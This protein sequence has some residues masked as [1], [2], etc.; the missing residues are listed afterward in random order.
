[1]ADTPEKPELRKLLK[2]YRVFH[3][4]N[5]REA[6]GHEDHFQAIQ[7]LGEYDAKHYRSTVTIDEFE[8]EI[9]QLLKN[10]KGTGKKPD[11]L[12]GLR[13]TKRLERIL[14][15]AEGPTGEPIRSFIRT[16]PLTANCQPLLFPFLVLEAKSEKSDDTFSKIRLQTSFSIRALL[17][18]Q[19]DLASAVFEQQQPV[20]K[21]LVWFLSNKGEVWRLAG[22][23]VQET[24]D[25]TRPNY[26]ILDLWE[27][28]ITYEQHALRLL[29]TLD[30]IFDWA[31]DVYRKEITNCLLSL[32][33]HATA[34]LAAE[35]DVFS[36]LGNLV[37]IGQMQDFDAEPVDQ[38]PQPFDVPDLYK[39]FD[40]NTLAI[41]DARY[42]RF[43]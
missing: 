5:K 9:E 38:R 12:F 22:A 31:R 8:A 40:T 42:I 10:L 27:G 29:L 41:R 14:D 33:A 3:D 34:S 7:T 20:M 32:A 21:P 39:A 24:K 19:R 30:Y 4:Q 35:T 2:R 25:V 17:K 18:L 43:T 28:N 1:M 15:D 36:T 13:V 26:R 6:P 11:R 23:Y 37:D 16:S